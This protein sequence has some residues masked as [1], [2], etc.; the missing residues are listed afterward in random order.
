MEQKS[1][2]YFERYQY[3]FSFRMGK[4]RYAVAS[5]E[6]EPKKFKE[7]GTIVSQRNIIGFGDLNFYSFIF[8]LSLAFSEHLL[9]SR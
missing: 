4:W 5:L 6:K 3:L 1:Y 7:A 8:I 9:R 2:C